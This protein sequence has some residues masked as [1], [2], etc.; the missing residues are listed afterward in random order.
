MQKKP[1]ELDTS[2]LSLIRKYVRRTDLTVLEI[3]FSVESFIVHVHIK[4]DYY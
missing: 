4:Y 1:P 2:S 3:W